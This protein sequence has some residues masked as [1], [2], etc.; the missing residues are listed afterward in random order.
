MSSSEE[1]EYEDLRQHFTKAEWAR[2]LEWEKVRYKNMKRNHLAMIAIAASKRKLRERKQINYVEEEE[3]LDDH[4]LYCDEC[5]T[6]Y[7]EECDVHG[8]PLFIPDTHVPLGVGDRARQTLPP[9]LQVKPSGIAG[10]GLG[11][12]NCGDSAVAQGVHY[13]PYE[14]EVMDKDEAIESG[15]SWVTFKSRHCDMYIDAKKE[16]HSNWMRYVNCARNEEEQNLVAFQFRGGILY[17]CCRPLAVGEELLVWYGEEYARDLGISFDQLWERKS[18]AGAR[19]KSSQTK[20]FSC[21]ECRYSYTAQIYLHK[22]IKRC[23]HDLYVS[24]LQSGKISAGSFQSTRVSQPITTSGTCPVRPP[25]KKQKDTDKP[26]RHRCDQCGKSFSRS[27]DLQRHQRTHTGEKPFH[28]DQCEKSFSLLGSLQRHQR[29]H[30]GEKPFHCDQCGKSFSR[31]GSLQR[32]QRTHT[33]EKPFHCDQCEKSFSL[34]GSLQSHQRTHT[35][36]KPF[37]CDQCGKS[38]S[39]L[40]SLQ[41]HQRTHTGEKPFHCDQCE[42]RFSLLG[43]LQSHQRTHTGE[44][45]YHCD[46]CEKSFSRLGSLQSHQRT[47][48]GE[49]PYHCDQCGKSFS[50]SSSVSKH[51]CSGETQNHEL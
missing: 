49:K 31:L 8:P 4:Y 51:A 2:L 9:G 33:G 5:K 24:M 40:G 42:K 7:I 30:T 37:H 32:H 20:V 36:E 13:G 34:L 47:H 44:K 39:L 18:S 41:R 26:R 27:G 17:R 14:G 16:T 50:W 29:T 35:G 11:V 38:F 23:H 3:P 1:D 10:A 28:C 25:T 45:P 21:S 15:Y 46:Q 6:F 12:F 43:S 48:T 22:H 19:A